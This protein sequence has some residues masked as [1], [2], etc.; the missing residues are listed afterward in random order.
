MYPDLLGI[1]GVELYGAAFE[2][3][4]WIALCVLMIWGLISSA[5]LF[6]AARKAEGI[7]QGVI[8]AIVLIW[9]AKKCF[10]SFSPDYALTF[11]APIVLHSYAFC[12]I[13]GIGL[14]IWTA[15]A[16]ARR[17][18]FD[19]NEMSRL[20]FLLVIFGFVGARLVHVL[21]EFPTYRDSCF[22][23]S[24]VGLSQ[25]DCMRALNVSEGG[26]TFYGGVLAGMAVLAVF[27]FRRCR[28]GQETSTLSLADILASALSITHAFGRIGCVAA[29]CCWGAVTSGSIGLHYPKGSFA[30]EALLKDPHFHDIVAAS[31]ETPLMHASQLY[32][33]GAEL[34]IYAVLWALLA[35]RAK[36]G[37]MAGTWLVGYGAVRFAVEMLRDDAERGYFFESAWP[38]VNGV[39]H[40]SPDH[41]TILTT[42]QGIALFMIAVGT[43]VL[44]Y[45]RRKTPRAE[46]AG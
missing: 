36:P 23:P 21:V 17:R 44:I 1:F 16:Q 18:N 32:E 43:G 20:C 45:A 39:L 34:A 15:R 22:N 25:P 12:I 38:W 2:R 10:A 42:S 8:V 5:R 46:A 9:A 13:V 6:F 35:R 26:L 28:R 31:G 33:A 3:V 41:P 30:Y 24:A 37:I 29:G 4:L 11:S 40:I 7:A 27:F 19:P 14:G